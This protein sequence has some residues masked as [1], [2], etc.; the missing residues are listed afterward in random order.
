MTDGSLPARRMRASDRDRDAVLEMLQEAHAAGRLDVTEL[1]ERQDQVLSARYQDEL[2]GVLD[3]LPEGRALNLSGSS[4]SLVVPPVAPYPA[5][6]DD[7]SWKLAVLSSKKVRL[8]PGQRGFRSF[9]WWGGD[10][11]D[12]TDAMGPG[13]VVTLELPGIMGGNDIV[14]PPGVRIRDE[15]LAIMAGNDI[16][17]GA[18]GDGSNGTL[19]LKGFLFWAGN[20][21]KLRQQT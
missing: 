17:S 4:R 5:L 6:P 10:D 21:I 8:A 16:E 12:V 2:V 14:V 15:S 11:I 7:G 1:A 19:I 20:D 9:A 18:Q 13:V 3:D